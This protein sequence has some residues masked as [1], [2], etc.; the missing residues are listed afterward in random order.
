MP[1]GSFVVVGR[2][3]AIVVALAVATT[4]FIAPA[5]SAAPTTNRRAEMQRLLD[6]I[7]V[8]N[9]APGVGLTFG[10]GTRDGG[11]TP[12]TAS[13]TDVTAVSAGGTHTCAIR[14]GGTLWCWGDNAWGQLGASAG[15]S[16]TVPL[17]VVLPP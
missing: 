5:A 9:T 6:A 10:N 7:R 12:I 8:D 4:L 2:L 1:R 11:M 17:Q 16:S 3:G 14:D 13:L 15:L